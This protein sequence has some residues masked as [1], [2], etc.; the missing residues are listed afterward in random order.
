MPESVNNDN[1]KTRK[2]HIIKY[3]A[4]YRYYVAA[5]LVAIVFTAIAVLASGTGLKYIID[6]G[7]RKGDASFYNN[8][9][10]AFLGVIILL[11]LASYSRVMLSSYIGERM[12]S[13]IRRDIY[14]SI[15]LNPITF[16]EKTPPSDIVTRISSDASV[17]QTVVTGSMM[18]AVRNIILLIGGTVMLIITSLTLTEYVALIIPVVVLPILILGKRVRRLSRSAQD[19]VASLSLQVDESIRGIKI[20]KAYGMEGYESMRFMSASRDVMSRAMNRSKVRAVLTSLVIVLIFSSILAVLWIGGRQVM[21]GEISHGELSAFIFYSVIVAS[22]FGAITEVIGDMQRA[23][24]AADRLLEMLHYQEENQEQIQTASQLKAEHKLLQ[25]NIKFNQVGFCYPSRENVASLKDFTLEI[26]KGSRVALVGPSGAGKT[27]V[28]RL[29]L[30]FYDAQ[31]GLITIDGVDIRSIP[32]S[33]LRSH[34]AYVPQDP[35]I[36]STTIRDNILYGRDDASE[37]EVIEAAKQA[38][39]WD[40]IKKLPQGLDTFLGNNA[41]ALSGGQKQRLAIARAI[42]RNPKILLLDEATSSLDSGNE[43]QIQKAIDK[44]MQGRTTIVIAHRLETIIKSDKIV[45]LND[46]KI[47][48]IGTHEEL[49]S[50]SELYKKLSNV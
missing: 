17:L 35:F 37:E 24:G 8:Y 20:I 42:L 47:E 28:L 25:G 38:A 26:E 9:F 2:S 10:I 6:E 33:L 45:V 23:A 21:Q 50:T 11:G 32:V 48:S 34:I 22:S 1:K 18:V 46:G 29:L 15:I 31:E 14:N 44:L 3:L 49:L 27:T 19:S 40:F 43:K 36:F 30:R 41:V 13:D 16:F 5:C 12:I 7:L 4:P 39:A